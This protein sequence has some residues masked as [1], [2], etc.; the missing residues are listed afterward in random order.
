MSEDGVAQALENLCRDKD[1]RR[2]F[3]E[4]AR[5]AALDTKYSWDAIARQFEGLFEELVSGTQ[6]SIADGSRLA[7]A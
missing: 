7:Q 3:G 2:A 6:T 1:R 5:L 4:A